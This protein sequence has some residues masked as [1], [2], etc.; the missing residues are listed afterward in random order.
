MGK[1]LSDNDKR[2]LALWKDGVSGSDIAQALGVTKGSIMGR[3]FRLREMG[4]STERERSPSSPEA[5]EPKVKAEKKEK[6][7][8][9]NRIHFPPAPRRRHGSGISILELKRS[10]C[11]YIVGWC[12]ED[13][14]LYCGKEQEQGSYC[15][16]H[17]RLCYNPN[18]ILKSKRKFSFSYLTGI[19][20]VGAK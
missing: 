8:R 18:A 12:E 15:G 1:E 3:L 10:S 7:Y 11:R 13:L 19:K 4:I 14:H 6:V 16:A 17:A 9:T 2:I 5:K 20:D